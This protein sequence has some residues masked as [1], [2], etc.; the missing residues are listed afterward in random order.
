MFYTATFILGLIVGVGITLGLAA[1]ALE[2]DVD[3]T[4][5]V[6]DTEFL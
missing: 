1:L 4:P 2:R 6:K 3:A 5:V